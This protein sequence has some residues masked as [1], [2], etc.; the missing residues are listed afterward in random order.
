[1]NVAYDLTWIVVEAGE[2][3]DETASLIGKSGMQT[4]HIRFDEAFVGGSFIRWK[5]GCGFVD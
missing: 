4:V 2:I 1:M 5:L 3:G